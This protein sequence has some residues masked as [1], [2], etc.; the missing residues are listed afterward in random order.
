MVHSVSGWTQGVQV[1]LWDP[2]RMCAIP[3]R[4]RGVFTARRY[5][6]PRVPYRTLPY[7]HFVSGRQRGTFRSQDNI[8][9][10]LKLNCIIDKHL[11]HMF[12]FTDIQSAFSITENLNLDI[13]APLLW[14]S[15]TSCR[16][17]RSTARSSTWWRASRSTES[18]TWFTEDYWRVRTSLGDE[19][20]RTFHV[21]F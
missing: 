1:R 9:G 10:A 3:E 20:V 8:L 5:T 12:W 16:T 2:L 14:F 4:L 6:N 15:A 17:F 19:W 18:L 13:L 11:S 7:E 21:L